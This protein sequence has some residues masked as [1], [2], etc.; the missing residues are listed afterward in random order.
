VQASQAPHAAPARADASTGSGGQFV[1]VQGRILDTRST[2]PL[3]A[4]T[5]E[6]VQVDGQAQLPTSG[7]AAVAV[8]FT[9]LTPAANGYLKAD[10][11]E[12]SA[13]STVTYLNWLAGST[14]SNSGVLPVGDDGKIQVWVSSSTN[15]L[16]DVQGYYTSGDPAAGGYVPVTQTRVLDTRNGTGG[17]PE[18]PWTDGSTKTISITDGP[19]DAGVPSDASAVMVNFLV[20]DQTAN[21]WLQPYPAD[22]AAPQQS[23]NF[24]GH[25]ADA[26]GATVALATGGTDAGAIKVDTHMTDG[27][28]TDLIIDVLGYF[29]STNPAA[30]VFTPGAAKVYDSYNGADA[31]VPAGETITIPVLGQAGVPADGIG[32]VAANIV[33]HNESGA[34]GSYLSAW[35]SEASEPTASALYYWASTATSNMVN[36]AV[37]GADGA[38]QVHNKGT[39][40]VKLTVFV[41]GWYAREA[42][43]DAVVSGTVLNNGQPEPDV[44]VVL[45]PQESPEASNNETEDAFIPAD[46]AGMTRTDASG[47]FEISADPG[48][49]P[50]MYVS[51]DGIV[52]FELDVADDQNEVDWNFPTT[53]PLADATYWPSAGADEDDDSQT[54]AHI[55]LGAGTA[56]DDDN[57]PAASEDSDGNVAGDSAR[58][59][60]V[61]Q[62]G[63]AVQKAVAMAAG[64]Q[65]DF[66]QFANP[67]ST[68]GMPTVKTMADAPDV[69]APGCGFRWGRWHADLVETFMVVHG[70]EGAKA[71]V[72]ESTASNHTMG[73]EVSTHGGFNDMTASGTATD[74]Y[75]RKTKAVS[76]LYTDQAITNRVNYRNKIFTCGNKDYKWARVPDGYYDL[77]TNDG[78]PVVTHPNYQ[79]CGSHAAGSHWATES[80]KSATQEFGVTVV[81]IG[82]TAQSGFGTSQTITFYFT[83]DG[84]VCG[85]SMQGPVH[86]SQVESKV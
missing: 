29:T 38:I 50:S 15:M 73:V 65:A 63:P 33:V 6:K 9:V 17:F 13:N 7:I 69:A 24:S 72:T 53:L 1:P 71:E 31:S 37:G 84:E 59:V 58:T 66:G 55:D 68:L 79:N 47:N 40:T 82:L 56:Y 85:N 8:N 5:W 2:A 16:I 80:A 4:A 25:A 78:N 42:R 43:T 19:V 39:L 34:A 12:T 75:T 10:K 22:G 28:S 3:P 77:M 18:T 11:D 61:M 62:S 21:G 76:P 27:G 36:V 57:D 41:E 86:S 30:G 23:L 52:N 74:S 48:A 51:S 70:T 83:Q 14:Q 45:L 81:G 26:T 46:I 20:L 60:D 44:N 32:A 64:N 35:A 54:A 49:M 67:T